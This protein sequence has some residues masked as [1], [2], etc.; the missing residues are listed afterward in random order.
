[1]KPLAGM[2]FSLAL[3]VIALP[4]LANDYKPTEWKEL[5]PEGFEPPPVRSQAYYDQNPEEAKQSE[6]DAPMVNELDGKKI[7]IPGYVVQLEGDADNVTEFLLVPYF[8]ACIH[9]PPPPPN[10]IIHVTFP[11]GV[12]YEITYDAVWVEGT[13]S[14]ERKESELAVVGYQMEAVKVES[15]Y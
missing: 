3:A 15:Y 13:V 6:I 8:G 2:M 12:P 7:R 4:S 9:V 1:M 14:V 5:I 10:Q 11:E